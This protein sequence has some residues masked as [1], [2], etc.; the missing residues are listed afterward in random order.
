[1]V[2]VSRLWWWVLTI[3][4]TA[5]CGGST[6]GE[7]TQ[8]VDGTCVVG[9][10][11]VSSPL[12]SVAVTGMSFTGDAAT[13]LEPGHRVP[14]SLTITGTPRGAASAAT[15]AV[16]VAVRLVPTGATTASSPMTCALGGDIVNVPADGRAVGVTPD[17]VIPSSCLAMGAS[18]GRFN[19]EVSLTLG[20]ATNPLS[21][22]AGAQ[23]VFTFTAAR[24]AS[25]SLPESRCRVTE[26]AADARCSFE[27]GVQRPATPAADV[28]FGI[29]LE[30]TV[31][32]LWPRTPPMDLR[33][34]ATEAA[35][36][37]LTVD[38]NTRVFGN[39]PDRHDDDALPGPVSLRVQLG[40]AEGDDVGHWETVPFR[41]HPD[42]SDAPQTSLEF[43][44]FNSG[45][46]DDE[47]LFLYLPTEVQDRMTTG[48]WQG[49]GLYTL[50]V[51]EVPMGWSSEHLATDEDPSLNGETRADQE[52]ANCR[53]RTVRFAS[54]LGATL[55]TTRS[56]RWGF[57]EANLANPN[58]GGLIELSA[59]ANYGSTSGAGAFIGGLALATLF[60]NQV[61]IIAGGAGA[62]G[63]LARPADS[64]ASADLTVLD[65]RIFSVRETLGTER[66]RAVT[67]MSSLE[68]EK[69][70]NKQFWV[71]F[72]PINVEACVRGELGIRG[73][74][75]VGGGAADLPTQFAGS[76]LHLYV[77]AGVTPFANV[78]LGLSAGLGVSVLSAGLYTDVTL[79]DFE[80]PIT[81]TGRIAP[82]PP[83]GRVRAFG[84]VSVDIGLTFLKGAFG[85][86]AQVGGSRYEHELGS[87]DG[88]PGFGA[89]GSMINVLSRDT[90]LFS[91]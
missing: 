43:T 65:N 74:V 87:W 52:D 36:A 73:E 54:A 66:E 15:A 2:K 47:T 32:T 70:K 4:W 6:C 76:P 51:C 16:Q 9:D 55:S 63:L 42:G 3:P 88:I 68:R 91:F 81:A 58:L 1:M 35:H 64:S 59:G 80:L 25:A 82:P 10:A 84:N 71:K 56:S 27:I 60:Q 85:V 67:R 17:L 33:A 38:V 90:P 8:L 79:V 62:T 45:S 57:R 72:I 89:R 50:R 48:A 18:S 20:E 41:R 12:A 69:C 21:P 30:S 7:G 40:P 34:G 13:A 22:P 5:S 78:G 75:A 28:T 53:V 29:G 23:T 77:R 46:T 31:G 19:V 44:S 37:N 86:Y 61:V 14:L 39:D 26:G 83:G 11:G 49:V 24:V